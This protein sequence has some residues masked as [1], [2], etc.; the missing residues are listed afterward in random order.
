VAQA[1][2][3]GVRVR[4]AGGDF[5]LAGRSYGVGTAII[6]V[7]ENGPD[8]AETLGRAAAYADAEVVVVDDSYVREGT[9]L[10]SGSARA[11]G[12]PRVLLVWD[13]PGG[14]LSTGWARYVLEQ[15]Y[16]QRT[17]AVRAASLGRTVLSDYDV[18]VFPSGNYGSAVGRGLLDRLQQWMRDGGTLVTLGESTRWAAREG[19]GLLST[20]TERRGGRA[21]GSDPPKPDAPKQPIEYLDAIAPPDEAPESVPGAILKV[22]LDTDH[23]LAAGTDGEIG[24]FVESDLVLSPITLDRGQNVGRFAPL[25]EL[26]MSGVVWEDARPQL[27]SKAYLVHQSVGRG[28]IVAFS[29]DPN[30]RA[31]TEATMLLFMN[32]VLL[33]PGR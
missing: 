25:D 5:V 13:E 20:V 15:R 26:V 33:G 4:S 27:A 17:T 2:R 21:E 29:E 10:G 1:L 18:I 31:Y 14:S 24:V 32:A 16:G 8:L 28:Q 11:L 22:L 6:R 9:S 12:E 30:Y 23:W 3:E 7:A 19:V